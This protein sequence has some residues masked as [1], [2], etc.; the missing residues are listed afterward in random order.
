M[1]NEHQAMFELVDV[2]NGLII[3]NPDNPIVTSQDW[4]FNFSCDGDEAAIF[5]HSQRVVSTV[6]DTGED[7]LEWLQSI[8]REL[9]SWILAIQSVQWAVIKTIGEFNGQD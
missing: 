8:K 2:L 3:D 6:D 1:L 7:K 4:P 9:E 5:L